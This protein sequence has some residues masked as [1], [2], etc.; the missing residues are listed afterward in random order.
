MSKILGEELGTKLLVMT[1]QAPELHNLR[2]ARNMLV[3]AATI[4]DSG[5][6]KHVAPR[7]IFSL[8]VSPAV[9]SREG[10][11]HYG[12]NSDPIPN[13][14]EQRIEAQSE[15]G[16]PMNIAFD[17]AKI[18]RPLMSVSESSDSSSVGASST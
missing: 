18:T 12:P 8:E 16:L 1:E 14:G 9:K 17:I 3:K 10:H 6:C 15:M 13:M 4:L 7:S 11:S 2:S 5:A